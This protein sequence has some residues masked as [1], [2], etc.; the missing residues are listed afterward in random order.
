MS[1]Q[2]LYGMAREVMGE[3][4]DDL[5]SAE[6]HGLMMDQRRVLLWLAQ[7]ITPEMAAIASETYVRVVRQRLAVPNPDARLYA[8]CMTAAI[9]D[10]IMSVAK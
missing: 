9:H 10:A 8:Y 4:I 3:T 7:N 5:S 2:I 6:L 1:N